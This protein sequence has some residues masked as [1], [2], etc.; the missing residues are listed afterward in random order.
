MKIAPWG[1]L[2]FTLI[3][4]LCSE[5]TVLAIAKPSPVPDF[6]VEK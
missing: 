5:I 4:P 3:V 2:S 1:V 6:L